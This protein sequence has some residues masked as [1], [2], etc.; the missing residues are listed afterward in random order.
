[1]AEIL[2][3]SYINQLVTSY[4]SNEYSKLVSPLET[5]KQKYS[6]LSSLWGSLRTNLDSLKSV[7]YDLKS[8]STSN[9]FN[10]K[11]A[12]LSNADFFSASADETANLSSYQM[13][14]NQLAKSDMLVSSTLTSG[15][16][17]TSMAGTHTFS[18]TSGDYTKNVSVDLTA[19]E[20]NS[21]IMSKISAAINS[22]KAT[23]E[24][25]SFD[26]SST[27]TGSGEFKL[28]I[29]DSQDEDDYT[30][31]TISYDYTDK[32]YDEIMDDLVSKIGSQ[33]G[34]DA[35]KVVDG[36]NVSL[37]LTGKNASKFV[38]MEALTDTG[39][40]LSNLSIDASKVMG[41]SGLA[42]GSVFSPMTG[43]SK[44][45]ITAKN[46]GYD[47]RLI[48]SDVSG[49][50]LDSVGLNNTL[51][52]NRT[53]AAGDNDAGYMY[54]SNSSTD[55]ELNA[56]ITFNGIN[57]QRNSN[58][59]DDLITGITFSL[60]SKMEDT[61]TTVNV[62]VDND[63]DSIKSKI[64][65]FIKAFNTSYTYI[66]TNQTTGSTDTRGLFS[67]DSTANSLK[68]SLQ[69]AVMQSVSGMSSSSLSRLSDIGVTFDPE[70]GLTLSD[71]TKLSDQINKDPD[72]VASL[73][74]STNGIAATLYSTVNNYLGSDGTISR[75]INSLDNNANYL[76]DRIES[77]NDRIDKSAE[78][79][80]TKYENLQMQLSVLMT[81]YNNVSSLFGS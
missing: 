66:R 38:S 27:F 57:V 60:K 21:S 36:S 67:G 7:L 70:I 80:R 44:L 64:E 40:L 46:S 55:N 34:I 54:T 10:T 37:K 31:T 23:I 22:D 29:G 73:F 51:L 16:A 30:E 20:T 32:T 50:I 41:A 63:T 12:S 18:I 62:K 9:I 61:D 4:T 24:S 81:S 58:T 42:T 3:T 25:S 59:F 48:L 79:L 43:D 49:S 19:S 65:E 78:V 45:S 53:L 68:S 69:N 74:N 76:K 72:Q 5:R 14:V 8:T 33:S 17:V 26:S 13:R 11:T 28:V 2:S 77:V 1:M 56:K 71:S 75:V 39:G 47:N 52:A 6:T 15:T 35:E